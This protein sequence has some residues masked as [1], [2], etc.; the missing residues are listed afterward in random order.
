MEVS[1]IRGSICSSFHSGASD[2]HTIRSM[3]GDAENNVED[4]EVE[5]QWA[6][7]ERLPTFKRLRTSLFNLVKGQSMSMIDVTKLGA[8]ERQDFINKLLTKVEDDHRYLLQKLR[9]RIDK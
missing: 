6:A 7:I 1:Q 8:P 5:L 3:H 2:S 9:E 4:D